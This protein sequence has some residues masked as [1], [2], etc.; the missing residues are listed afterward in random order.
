MAGAAGARLRG[1]RRVRR[2]VLRQQGGG[3]GGVLT[4]MEEGRIRRQP[5]ER[6]A[7]KEGGKAVE[8]SALPGLSR[9]WPAAAPLFVPGICSMPLVLPPGC[10][11]S[12]RLPS[13]PP[14]QSPARL[15]CLWPH[16]HPSKIPPGDGRT[17][18]SLSPRTP[19]ILPHA[20]APPGQSLSC[21]GLSPSQSRWLS[22]TT[23]VTA[24]GPSPSPRCPLVLPSQWTEHQFRTP[25][26]RVSHE[27]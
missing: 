18:P 21:P 11:S 4:A 3:G 26:E 9:S 5:S 15:P 13:H 1:E 27:G 14:A 24:L 16:A 25:K 20:C 8:R 22:L 19:G 17:S 12:G 10:G 7:L 23:G 6:P 2:S